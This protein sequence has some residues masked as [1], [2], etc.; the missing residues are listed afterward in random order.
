MLGAEEGADEAMTQ[1]PPH[2]TPSV[3]PAEEGPPQQRQDQ[4]GVE[5]GP[6]PQD[7]ALSAE[8]ME[9]GEG[10]PGPQYGALSKEPMGQTTLEQTQHQD[11]E[12]VD[13]CPAPGPSS[14][15]PIEPGPFLQTQVKAR[16]EI[17][18]NPQSGSPSMEYSEQHT[19]GQTQDLAVKEVASAPQALA[20]SM[21]PTEKKK[22]KAGKEVMTH[23]FKDGNPSSKTLEFLIQDPQHWMA[24]LHLMDMGSL[25]QTWDD[26]T[27]VD[28][29]QSPDSTGSVEQGRLEQAQDEE[30]MAAMAQSLDSMASLEPGRQEQTLDEERTE[31]M[32]QSPLSGDL[33]REPVVCLPERENKRKGGHEDPPSSGHHLAVPVSCKK[34]DGPVLERTPSFGRSVKFLL[35]P[36]TIEDTSPKEDELHFFQRVEP[37]LG[38][39]EN[40]LKDLFTSDEWTDLTEDKLLRKRILKDG[41]GE[42]TKPLPGQEVTVKLLGIQEDGTLVE[43]DPKMTFVLDEGDVIQALELGVQSMQLGEES[44]LLTDALYAFGL[45]GR[46]P[47]IP[48]EAS[49]L[50]EI[51]LL[52][53]QDGPSLGDLSAADCISLGNQKRECGNFHFERE[54]YRSAMRSYNRAL[55]ILESPETASLS[56]EEKQELCEHRIKCMN[57]I[58]AT[59][60]KLHLF[61][62]VLVSCNAVLELDMDNVKALYRKGKLLSERGDHE[63]AMTILKRALKLEPTTKAIHAELSKLVKRQKGIPETSGIG[64][65]KT[66]ALLKMRG[67]L[68]PLLPRRNSN[69]KQITP[70]TVIFGAVV[71]VAS[72]V[73]AVHLTQDG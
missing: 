44:F 70:W 47:D 72:I 35:P 1:R 71:A 57:N 56:T 4:A 18:P 31:V 5:G 60:L 51:T 22:D 17:A 36:I 2:G 21:E 7:R 15:E 12:K 11:W 38:Y 30:K 25:E 45:L 58:A 28:M 32:A 59:Q 10:A 37:M 20:S 62:Q 53:I 54:E 67:D 41:L 48:A 61:E 49:L 33:V 26:E 24:S 63:E 69:W 52:S 39:K 64:R 19:L 42:A 27:T 29:A 68:N 46:D 8:P 66:R 6:S 34:R 55:S 13:P 40:R 14:T 65:S 23:I 9:Q 16:K 43:K 50:Y 3:E 73:M